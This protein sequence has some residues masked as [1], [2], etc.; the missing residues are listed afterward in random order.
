MSYTKIA[1][2]SGF[3]LT[4][5]IHE[6]DAAVPG[7]LIGLV[8][9]DVIQIQGV[10]NNDKY[11]P[12][13]P[14]ELQIPVI[15]YS[16]QLISTFRNRRLTD[17]KVIVKD[18][19]L[20]II[21]EGYL[22]TRF[23]NHR[24]GQATN[25]LMINAF[26]GITALKNKSITFSRFA[27][28]PVG[29]IFESILHETGIT[30][31]VVIMTDLEHE[32]Q[33]SPSGILPNGYRVDPWAFVRSQSDPDLYSLLIEMLTFYKWQLTQE[34]GLWK[35]IERDA[36]ADSTLTEYNITQN[37]SAS[38]DKE[39]TI[40]RE[41][42]TDDEKEDYIYE[43][44]QYR[45]D[46]SLGKTTYEFLNPDFTEWELT[47]GVYTRLIGWK[48]NNR[49]WIQ[50]SQS[51]PE[52][53]EFLNTLA[54]LEQSPIVPLRG[55]TLQLKFK[56]EF[57]LN[58]GITTGFPSTIAFGEIRAYS[59]ASNNWYS[60]DTETGE[61]NLN[62]FDRI[63]F[64]LTGTGYSTSQVLEYDKNVDDFPLS[65]GVIQVRIFFSD[66]AA[67]ASGLPTFFDAGMI[68]D[69]AKS[70][71]NLK[72]IVYDNAPGPLTSES[73]TV[74][75]NTFILSYFSDHEY[76]TGSQ[77]SRTS[78]WGLGDEINEHISKQ[79]VA[80][81]VTSDQL[82]DVKTYLT[83][84]KMSSLINSS[85]TGTNRNYTPMLIRRSLKEKVTRLYCSEIK[86][87]TIGDLQITLKN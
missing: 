62:G 41:D 81:S 28:Q 22:N 50:T 18:F 86:K 19:S 46:I 58:S 26:D 64:D 10:A 1:E 68:A 59:T 51:G 34:D 78:D 65:T 11:T 84:L 71:Y 20:S 14:H 82:L 80:S 49:D 31:D 9:Q 56:V 4:V 73:F 6:L 27:K 75:D 79:I 66:P 17:F 3:D 74:F 85:V 67:I 21:Y 40:T 23:P 57:E 24:F 8:L 36:R 12:H 38:P 52:S 39:R 61:W 33:S 30:Q 43:I 15:D 29:E 13:L 70:G 55:G 53:V 37:T 76:Y 63:E 83:T 77:W 47:D 42:L 7:S 45:R 69:D 87:E 16:N 32:D 60:L 54:Q 72:Q 2:S 5:E 35:I 44:S 25:Q 48:V